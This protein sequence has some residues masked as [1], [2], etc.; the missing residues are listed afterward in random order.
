MLDAWILL[1]THLTMNKLKE[2]NTI[3]LSIGIY[4]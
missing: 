2:T 1:Q 3:T 4:I